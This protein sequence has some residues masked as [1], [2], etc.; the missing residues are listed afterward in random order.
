[1]S[2]HIGNPT[3][4]PADSDTGPFSLIALTKRLLQKGS[5]PVTSAAHRTVTTLDGAYPPV[6]SVVGQFWA[7]NPG[8]K[9]IARFLVDIVVRATTALA[10]D[11]VLTFRPYIR[12]GGSSGYVAAGESVSFARPRLKDDA[13]QIKAQF[14]TDNGGTYTNNSTEV[15]DNTTGVMTLNSLDTIANGD[16][17]VLGGPAPFCGA[18][19]DVTNTNS[20]GSITFT[21]EY[22]NGSAW[23]AL[24]NLT[25]G[26]ATAFGGDA[27]VTW[28]LPA[29][30]AWATSTINSVGPF[31]W[32]RLGVSGAID[33]SVTL[34]EVDLLFPIK[35]AIDV[36][37]DGDDATLM[38][39]S[40]AGGTGTLAYSGSTRVS[41]R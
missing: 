41:W 40:V 13:A 36:Q 19:L 26:N 17:V 38:L 27:Q 30:G 35:A 18:A 29:A 24:S 1:M 2:H 10:D 21:A 14:T 34:S 28:D 4:K 5:T 31:Y 20:T 12:H 9:S 3:D 37:A 11:P 23:T 33:D 22:W 8:G 16:W 25:N 39:E 15:N 32:C 7:A 6:P